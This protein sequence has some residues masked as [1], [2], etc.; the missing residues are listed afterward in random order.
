[1][2]TPAPAAAPSL[3]DVVYELL[4][5]HADTLRLAEPLADDP[6]WAVHTGYL[7][8]L[9]RQ[10]REALAAACSKAGSAG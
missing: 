7:R 6:E 1:V 2:P 3:T 10:G 4:D 8:D 9:G 5:A